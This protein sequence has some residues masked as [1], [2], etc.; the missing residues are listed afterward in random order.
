[1]VSCTPMGGLGNICFQLSAVLS[2]AKKWGMDYFIPTKVINPHHKGSSPHIFPNINYSDRELNLPVYI[3][4]GFTYTEI[5]YMKNVSLQGYFQSYKYHYEYRDEILKAFGFDNIE[6]VKDV[7]S[8]HIRRTDYLVLPTIHP[9]VSE[10]YIGSAILYMAENN[11]SKFK[12]FSDDIEWCRSHFENNRVY[13]NF[14]FEYSEGKTDLDDLRDMAAC[15][16]NVI[17]NS[18]FSWFGQ[19]INPNPN[20]KVC[21]PS[22]WFGDAMPNSTVDLFMPYFKII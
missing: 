9:V 8:I 12:V 3:E 1:M 19:Y 6:T 13:R 16:H 4:P 2:Y 18:S 17:A 7:S 22:R 21:A 15:E 20:K 10:A 5:P 11:I 14:E